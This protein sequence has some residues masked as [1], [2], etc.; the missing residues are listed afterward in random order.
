[1]DHDWVGLEKV[2]QLFRYEMWSSVL[3]E[4]IVEQGIEVQR[5]GPL[6]ATVFREEPVG[7]RR[8]GELR[9]LRAVSALR[10]AAG[11]F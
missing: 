11:A 2:A 7:G 10:P 8:L 3:P 5:F 1:M 6:Q 9:S 4:A